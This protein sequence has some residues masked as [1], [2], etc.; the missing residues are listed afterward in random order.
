MDISQ[1]QMLTSWIQTPDENDRLDRKKNGTAKSR[2]S[3][4]D[5]QNKQGFSPLPNKIIISNKF[6]KEITMEPLPETIPET[7]TLLKS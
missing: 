2:L 5:R 3:D 7:Y 1:N 6:S 4:F